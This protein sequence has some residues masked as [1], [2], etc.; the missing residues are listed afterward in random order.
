MAGPLPL[1]RLSFVASSTEW[2]QHGEIKFDSR[3]WAAANDTIA[4]LAKTASGKPLGVFDVH[5]IAV[6][7]T[8]SR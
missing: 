7:M 5:L 8:E 1:I 2:R 6:K 3:G 4:G